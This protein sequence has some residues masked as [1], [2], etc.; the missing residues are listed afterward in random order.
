MSYEHS[1]QTPVVGEARTMSHMV[2]KVFS[3]RAVSYKLSD[4]TPVV[5]QE[6]RIMS[7]MVSKGI[8]F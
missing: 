5:G 1:D 8:L 3:T 7:H 6:A 4:H 2:S